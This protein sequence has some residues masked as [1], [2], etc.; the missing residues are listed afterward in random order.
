MDGKSVSNFKFKFWDKEANEMIGPDLS[1]V[2]YSIVTYQGL[3]LIDNERE[4]EDGYPYQMDVLFRGY[5]GMKDKNGLEIYEGDII[6]SSRGYTAAVEWTD[7]G[8][9]LGRTWNRLIV[10]VG[11]EPAVEVIGNIYENPELLTA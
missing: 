10:Y 4:D 9:F 8:R 1:P 11:Q 6:K 2:R 3:A 7:D 5:T